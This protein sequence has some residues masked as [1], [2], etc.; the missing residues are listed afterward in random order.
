M[1]KKSLG[2]RKNTSGKKKVFTGFLSSH[3]SSE[4]TQQVNW[5][6]LNQLQGQILN[7]TDSAKANI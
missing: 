1:K 3:P 6:T 5:F 4:L 2:R 7:E